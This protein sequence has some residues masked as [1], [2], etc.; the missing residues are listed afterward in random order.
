MD[1]KDVGGWLKDNGGSLVGLVGSIATGNIAGAA[2]SAASLMSQASGSVSPAEALK[3]FQTD[4]AT[5]VK[6]EELA[7][8]KEEELRAHQRK[9]LEMELDDKQKEHE[10]QQL[11][12]R[13]GDTASD[14]YVRHTRPLMARQ[15]WYGAAAYVFLFEFLHATGL[16]QIGA[17]WEIAMLLLSP[18]AAYLGFRTADKVWGKGKV[19]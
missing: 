4:P 3:R 2:A 18:S 5:L 12:I 8:Q 16:S 1:W 6:L 7:A 11:T 15:S 13:A 19:L 10:Q 17:N 14:E 9:L